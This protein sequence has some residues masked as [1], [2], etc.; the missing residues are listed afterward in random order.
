MPTKGGE[1]DQRVQ[2]GSFS[3]ELAGASGADGECEGRM[4]IVATSLGSHAVHVGLVGAPAL[5]L[6]VLRLASRRAR[7]TE[8]TSESSSTT[9]RTRALLTLLAVLSVA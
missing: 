8:T 2:A 4:T 5:L 9:P 3:E 1:D 7:P 6:S